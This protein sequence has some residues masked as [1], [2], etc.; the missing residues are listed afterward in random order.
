[1]L[2]RGILVVSS[3]MSLLYLSIHPLIFFF[4]PRVKIDFFLFVS[5]LHFV[6]LFI[7]VVTTRR[8]FCPF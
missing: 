2:T 4:R 8:L 1:M 6:R 7:F 5:I 3:L